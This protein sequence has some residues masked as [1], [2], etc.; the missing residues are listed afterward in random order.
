MTRAFAV[1]DRARAPDPDDA[2][3]LAHDALVHDRRRRL[4]RADRGQVRGIA[5]DVVGMRGGAERAAHEVLAREPRELA[6]GA[7]H[8][9]VDTVGRNGGEAHR[10]VLEDLHDE[11]EL[12]A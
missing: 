12:E 5:L 8:P 6:E 4:A 9:Q 1:C 10:G 3:V 2:P 7:V 11:I